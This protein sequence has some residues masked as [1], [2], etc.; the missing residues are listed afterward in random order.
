MDM[1]TYKNLEIV[2]QVQQY[3]RCTVLL[4]LQWVTLV[5]VKTCNVLTLTTILKVL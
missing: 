2:L 5:Y 1:F 4:T 3:K